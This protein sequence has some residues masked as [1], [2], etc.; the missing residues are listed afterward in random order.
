M[1][2]LMTVKVSNVD[3]RFVWKQKEFSLSE[4]RLQEVINVIH[5][6]FHESYDENATVKEGRLTKY[7]FESGRLSIEAHPLGVDEIAFIKTAL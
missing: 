3:N 6:L 2:F 4:S 7:T 5:E 1:K